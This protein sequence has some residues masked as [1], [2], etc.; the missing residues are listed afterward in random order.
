MRLFYGYIVAFIS[1]LFISVG[2]QAQP[3]KDTAYI[4]GLLKAADKELNPDSAIAL[5][6]NTLQLSTEANYPDGAFKSLITIGIK[7]YEKEDYPNYRNSSFNALKWAEQSSL[8]DA[9]AWCYNNI[10]ESYLSEGDYSKASEYLYTALNELNKRTKQPSHT[11]AN[12]Y[13]NL[14]KLNIRIGQVAKAMVFYDLAET[15]EKQAGLN[16]QLAETYTEKGKYYLGLRRPDS[17][18]NYFNRVMEIGKQINKVDLQALTYCNLGKAAVEKGQ[19]EQAIVYLEK[20]IELAK[21]RFNDIVIDADYALGDLWYEQGM[22]KKAEAITLQAVGQTTSHNMKDVYLSGYSK[23]ARIYEAEGK[24]KEALRFT[25]ALMAVKDS[26]VNIENAK[27]INQMEIK[28]QTSEKDREIANN[29]LLLEKQNSKIAK[30]N[31]WIITVVCGIIVLIIV[32]I[33]VWLNARN[34]QR[35]HE[36]E[37]KTLEKEKTIGALKG[38]VQGAD[39]ER[40]RIARELHDGVGGMLSAAMMQFRSMKRDKKEIADMPAYNEALDMLGKIGDE[41]RLTAHDLMPEVL[42]KQPLDEAIR[43]YCSLMQNGSGLVIDFQSMGVFN[44]AQD[45]KLNI[46]RVVQELVK[47]ITQHANATNAL[48]QLQQHDGVISITVEDNGIGFDKAK[49]QQQAGIG[50]RNIETRILSMSGSLE[51]VTAPGNGTAVYI[52]IESRNNNENENSHS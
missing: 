21:N 51:I 25:V 38:M 49:L 11:T 48:V 30:K 16:F 10:G 50:L 8:E 1:I 22:L 7:Y 46:Y 13:N 52:E 4:N 42:S 36:E 43:N 35:L 2:C 6:R 47:N 44:I 14:A 41:I 37:I 39:N 33:S 24:Y 26:L 29:Q 18:I 32:T 9:V 15:A 3:A 20:A 12:I 23:L 5:F 40:S 17:A 27:A 34:K 28:Y 31:A 19:N 45:V